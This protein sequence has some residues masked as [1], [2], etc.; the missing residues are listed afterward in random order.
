MGDL[1]A[2]CK[3]TVGYRLVLYTFP[4]PS[5]DNLIE[6]FKQLCLI[7]KGEVRSVLALVQVHL[8]HTSQIQYAVCTSCQRMGKGVVTVDVN[9][10][11]PVGPEQDVNGRE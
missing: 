4:C 8:S 3:T 5:V 10:L 1:T 6:C 11:N 7:E 9:V 2:T